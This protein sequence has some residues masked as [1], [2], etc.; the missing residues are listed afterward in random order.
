M[1]YSPAPRR[2]SIAGV[3]ECWVVSIGPETV[4]KHPPGT[5]CFVQDG[6][7]FEPIKQE[8]LW[9][10]LKDDEAYSTLKAYVEEVDGEVAVQIVPE[11]SIL[12]I[13]D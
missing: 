1:L 5:K 11:W 8:Y 12:A 3:Q 4:E 2:N 13:E 6:F 10:A 9:D 7:E